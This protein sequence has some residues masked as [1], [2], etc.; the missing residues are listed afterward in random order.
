MSR[1]PHQVVHYIQTLI[2]QFH[3]YFS[4]YSK[5]ERVISDDK[6]KTLARLLLC[7]ALQTTLK[8]MLGLLG[9]DA[10]ER[11]YLEDITPSS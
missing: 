8:A 4:Q 6:A 7:R 11:M 2:S 5:T 3:S 10:P 9:V 1:E